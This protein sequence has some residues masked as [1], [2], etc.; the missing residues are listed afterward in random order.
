MRVASGTKSSTE[1]PAAQRS[2][3]KP[4]DLMFMYLGR[5]GAL[6]RFTL[7]LAQCA[8]KLEGL[9]SRIVVSQF[10]ELTEE[11]KRTGAEVLELP[12]F[13]GRNPVAL[14]RNFLW[15][16]NALIEEIKRKRPAAVITL[17]PHIWTPLLMKAIKRRGVLYASI[18]HDVVAHPGDGTAAMLPWLLRDAKQADLTLTLSRAVA[19]RL[20]TL[21]IVK[22]EKTRTLFHPDLNFGSE[23]ANRRRNL[24]RPFRLLFF[25]RIMIYKGLPLLIEAVRLLRAEGVAVELGVAGA[26]NLSDVRVHLN[27]IDAEIVNRWLEDSEI[28]S[29]LARYDAVVCSH[30]EAS[31]SGV[32]A[33]AFGNL[34]PVVAT[35]VGALVE[36]VVDGK[37]GVL[38]NS[39]SARSLAV[40]IRRLMEEPHLYERITSNLTA[41]VEERSMA[42]FV[43][44]LVSN[45]ISALPP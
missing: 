34:I 45:V 19:D 22:A 13:E 14:V 42:R 35:P 4:I 17:M 21:G 7:E 11:I 33:T 30:V 2:Q 27:E 26:G 10:G 32:A 40:A 31:Q 16:R 44:E 43:K 25:G 18:T 38:A 15:A 8:A 12:T 23:R 28:G 36:Q 20:L 5:R 6:G 1:T 3:G 24:N 37:T 9:Q 41:T 39:V 29:L